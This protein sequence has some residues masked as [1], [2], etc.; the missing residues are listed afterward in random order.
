M[1]ANAIALQA[2]IDAYIGVH[3]ALGRQMHAQ[4]L[5]LQEFAQYVDTHSHG[6]P[7]RAQV[8][9]DWACATPSQRG[10]SGA[11]HRLS[12]VRGFLAY[13]R[14][15][16]PETEVPGQ[17]L[18]ATSRW[19]KPFLFTPEQIVTLIDSAL[20][21]GPRGSLRPYTLSTL[22]GLLASTGLRPGEVIRLTLA[23][24]QLDLSPPHLCVKETKF[25]KSRL[26]PLH[27]ST[28]DQLKSYARQRSTLHYAGLSDTFFV[29]E[30][31]QP[32]NHNSLGRWFAQ[33][34]R[35]RDFWPADDTRQPSLYSL[36]HSFAI[37]RLRQWY[38]Q[39]KEAQALLPNLS[40]YLGHLGPKESYW[41]LT[42]TPELLTAAAERFERHVL[43]GEGS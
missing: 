15:T 17:R 3:Q 16:L 40:V 2:Q 42:A 27:P 34:C 39:G 28:A 29:S 36:R 33:L 18:L 19:R 14:A 10:G 24:L 20:T 4:R 13:L 6:G 37:E 7:I 11:A 35:Q 5:L 9:F 23:D 12:V 32:L 38:R 30:K 25:Y 26:V 21:V 31:G 22:I 8:A 41:Y 1:K 43:S